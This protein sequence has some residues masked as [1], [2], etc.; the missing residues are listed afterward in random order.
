MIEGDIGESPFECDEME[1][2]RR[3]RIDEGIHMYREMSNAEEVGEIINEEMLPKDPETR[4]KAEKRILTDKIK[5]VNERLG[6][7][8]KMPATKTKIKS[9]IEQFQYTKHS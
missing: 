3:R 9:L 5:S 6:Q 7:V 8:D 2:M 4:K 1:R